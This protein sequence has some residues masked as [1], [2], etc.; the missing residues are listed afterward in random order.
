[1]SL[2]TNIST[3]QRATIYAK[4]MVPKTNCE[5]GAAAAV[6]ATALLTPFGAAIGTIGYLSYKWATTRIPSPAD[7]AHVYHPAIPKASRADFSEPLIENMKRKTNGEIL[8]FSYVQSK[9]TKEW[10]PVA[11]TRREEADGIVH[12]F[13]ES[14][15]FSGCLGYATV[16]PMLHYTNDKGQEVFGNPQ[17]FFI[18]DD[19]LKY[20]PEENQGQPVNKIYLQ[21]LKSEDKE[22]H[23]Y[24]GY[25]LIKTIQQVYREKCQGRMSVSAGYVSHGFYYRL[26]A[27]ALDADKNQ[28][29]ANDL[30]E[31]AITGKAPGTGSLMSTSMYL[32]ETACAEWL[33]EIDRDPI[34]LEIE[35]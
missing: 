27:R 33:A 35:G 34:S 8:G 5:R 12:F 30:C 20:G 15:G 1:M 6:V 23:K 29:I 11:I 22:L 21:A 4:A 3:C 2:P 17:Y 24:V 26:G 19:Q 28:F 31:S 7:Y 18:T 16:H 25:L 13:I 10:L 9:K 32:P 14:L